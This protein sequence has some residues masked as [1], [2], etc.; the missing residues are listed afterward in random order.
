MNAL[1]ERLLRRYAVAQARDV[2]PWI[3]GKRV[4][5]LGAGEGFVT[6][7]LGRGV[8]VDVGPFRRAPTPYVVYDGRRLPFDDGSFDTT[9]LLLVLHHCADP[10]AVLDEALRVT[11]QRLIVTESVHRHRLDLALLHLLD[12]RFN[13]WRHDGRM[14]APVAFRTSGEWEALFV[15]RGLRLVTARWL[16]SR[17][18]R[19][20]HHPRLY[21]LDRTAG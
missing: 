21:V 19:L 8:A 6:T 2:A 3:V 20:V 10:A 4:L 1:V 16:G 13:R 14:P 12:A 17:W 15:A 9:M 7:A 18:E 5:D 11:R